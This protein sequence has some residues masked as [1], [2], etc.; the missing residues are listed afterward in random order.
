MENLKESLVYLAT[1]PWIFL[2]ASLP[3]IAVGAGYTAPNSSGRFTA[4]AVLLIYAWF[5]ILNFSKYIQSTSFPASIIAA[6]LFS[7]VLLYFDQ[8]IYC[9]RIYEGRGETVSIGHAR[10]TKIN[11]QKA[12]IVSDDQDTFGSRFKFGLAV[13]GTIRAPGTPREVKGLPQFSS[14]DP[15]WVPSPMTFVVWRSAII[16]SCFM[17]N[18]YVVDVR[19]ALDHDLIQPSS[20]PFFSR[21]GHVTSKECWTRLIVGVST[22]LSAYCGLQVLF[23]IPPLISVCLDPSGRGLWRPAFGSVLD[24]YTLRGFWG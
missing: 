24:A 7:S 21:I 10:C 17:L 6:T 20:V 3:I 19:M 18:E 4:F 15:H 5:C 11:Q 14:S 1:N 8:L 9:Q 13:A 2:V 12:G 22:W 16:I 23:N